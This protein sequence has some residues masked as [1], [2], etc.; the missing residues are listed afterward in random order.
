MNVEQQLERLESE[1]SPAPAVPLGVEIPFARVRVSGRRVLVS[2]HGALG[3]DGAPKGSFGK[4]PSEI[5]VQR[6]QD[7]AKSATLAIP[8][9]LVLPSATSIAYRRG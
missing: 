3:Q 7:S 2:G 1:L 5:S 4:T 6:A 8:S 9:S